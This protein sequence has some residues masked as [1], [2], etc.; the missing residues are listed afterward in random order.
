[1]QEIINKGKNLLKTFNDSV[2]SVCKTKKID[3]KIENNFLNSL[4][5]IFDN[6]VYLKVDD[7]VTTLRRA[8]NGLCAVREKEDGFYTFA[9]SVLKQPTSQTVLKSI[10]NLSKLYK[11]GIKDRLNKTLQYRWWKY[12]VARKLEEWEKEIYLKKKKYIDTLHVNLEHIENL[13][14]KQNWKKN[15]YQSLVSGVYSTMSF[16]DGWVEYV[17]LKEND[18]HT[19]LETKAEEAKNGKFTVGFPE[20]CD[21]FSSYENYPF[22]TY[23]LYLADYNNCEKN[24]KML[25]KIVKA[26]KIYLKTIV[27]EPELPTKEELDEYYKSKK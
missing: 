27:K 3:S 25:N 20:L 21:M 24:T 16:L 22:E 6:D 1:M 12:S 10:K 9:D 7:L 18:S 4:C 11:P 2:D 8:F 26:M 13:L 17:R 23:D 19:S 14:S 15:D 5:S